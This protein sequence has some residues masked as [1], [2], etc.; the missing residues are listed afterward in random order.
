MRGALKQ[1]TLVRRNKDLAFQLKQ[2]DLED[3]RSIIFF[4]P[5]FPDSRWEDETGAIYCLPIEEP[6]EEPPEEIFGSMLALVLQVVDRDKGVFR[7][8][9][10]AIL[11]AHV[12]EDMFR[13][14]S[15][16]T[17]EFPCEEFIDGQHVFTII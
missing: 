12:S 13:E 4:D 8:A 11:D 2:P 6:P 7:R 15:D 10:L 5:P 17:G 9:G 16:T 3:N 1:P 14:C